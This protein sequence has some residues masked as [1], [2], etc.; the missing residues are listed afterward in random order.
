MRAWVNLAAASVVALAG[1]VLAGAS[2]VS[3]AL[4]R[5]PRPTGPW[6]VGTATMRLAGSSP[7][8]TTARLWYPAAPGTRGRRAPYNERASGSLRAR[9]VN[10]VVATNAVASAPVAPGR[11]PVIVYVPG[12]GGARESNSAQAENLASH[13]YVVVARDDAFPEAPFDFSSSAARDATVARANR[14]VAAAARD[15][16]AVLDALARNAADDASP[17]AGRLDTTRVGILGFSFGG[18]VAAEA[19]RHDPRVVAAVDLDGWLFGDA[20]RDG[21]PRAFLLLG[22]AL[23]TPS[24]NYGSGAARE[25]VAAFDRDNTERTF[26]GMRR[27]G[28]AFVT[29]DGTDHDNFT[30]AAWLPRLRGTGLGT[31]DGRRGWSLAANAILRFFDRSI[32][33]VPAPFFAAGTRSDGPLHVRAFRAAAIPPFRF[34]AAGDDFTVRSSRLKTRTFRRTFDS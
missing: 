24:P 30:D 23:D 33:R 8:A 20:L 34:I 7:A 9:L 18:A 2:G 21:V 14:K 1:C 25:L 31:I 5:A 11:F 28:G 26:A 32:E 27:Y 4:V 17:F 29:M 19:A 22:T 10:A 12:W 15:V 6:A 3:L 16:S 13:G